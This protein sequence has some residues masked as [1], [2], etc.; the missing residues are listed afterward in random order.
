SKSKLNER[1]TKI[2]KRLEERLTR[3]GK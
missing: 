3:I 1:A 2:E